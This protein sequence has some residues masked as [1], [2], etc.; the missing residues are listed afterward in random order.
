MPIVQV[1]GQKTP[2]DSRSEMQ[3]EKPSPFDVEADRYDQWF[4]SHEGKAIFEIEKNGLRAL[5]QT[6]TGLWLEVGAGSGRFATSL[7]ISEGV[8]PSLGMVTIAARRGIHVV[9]GTGEDLPYQDAIFH[10]VLTVTTL[11]FLINPKRTLSECRRV[12]R[13]FGTLVGGIVPAES[14]WG[15]LYWAKAQEGHPLYSKA[16]F[17]TC[18]QVIRICAEAGF[19][20]E[21]AVSCLS[22]PPGEE[23][24]PSLEEGIKESAGFVAMR[25]NKT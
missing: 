14:S 21:R 1:N 20:F 15:R 11:C 8:D 24:M 2:I 16:N 12:L 5:I 9:R 4:E 19:A 18:G 22:T 7:G 25:F 23:P 10:G 13:P 3:R 17:Y 6:V